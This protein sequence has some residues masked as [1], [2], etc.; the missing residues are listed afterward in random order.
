MTRTRNQTGNFHLC[1]FHQK[2]RSS[3]FLLYL[4][5]PYRK[6]YNECGRNLLQRTEAV[7]PRKTELQ[8]PENG[9]P[10]ISLSGEVIAND[11]FFQLYLLNLERPKVRRGLTILRAKGLR[12]SPTPKLCRLYIFYPLWDYWA[13]SESV[14]KE[15][16]ADVWARERDE[17]C[18][19]TLLFMNLPFNTCCP[20]CYLFVFYLF[21]F[22]CFS[23]FVW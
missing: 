9:L 6:L 8:G 13:H 10:G 11:R 16:F 23:C 7:D 12:K 2:C 18:S 4:G 3:S 19:I 15:G 22:S 17:C 20:F 1:Y 14:G 21:C 5:A